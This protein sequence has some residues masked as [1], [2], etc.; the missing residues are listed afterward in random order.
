MCRVL[1]ARQDPPSPAKQCAEE[2]V[3]SA[4]EVLS[5][6]DDRPPEASAL[7]L[8]ADRSLAG[9]EQLDG[10]PGTE[11]FPDYVTLS[12]DFLS[13]CPKENQYI[14]ERETGVAGEGVRMAKDETRQSCLSPCADGSPGRCD[15]E[16]RT[17]LPL[18]EPADTSD[19]KKAAGEVPG[20]LYSN[21]PC[22]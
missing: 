8:P 13:Q 22:S 10:S 1:L 12:R 11:V 3:P 15:F 21:L 5:E 18:A 6:D 9:R 20:N 2:T 7:L 17:Y 19:S 16:N 14:Y 4:V